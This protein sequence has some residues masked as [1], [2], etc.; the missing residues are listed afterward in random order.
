M[1]LLNKYPVKYAF[2]E[3]LLSY[4]IVTRISPFQNV[5]VDLW[6]FNKNHY[7]YWLYSF[8]KILFIVHFARL[9]SSYDFREEF[10]IPKFKF[11]F[12][13]QAFAIFVKLLVCIFFVLI[14]LCLCFLFFTSESVI[15]WMEMGSSGFIWEIKST[16]SLLLMVVT[17]LFTGGVEELFFRSFFITKLKQMGISLFISSLI[18]SVVF[19]YGHSYYGFIG[20][21]MSLIFGIIFAG[22]YLR[23]KN[24]YYSIFV[25]SFYNVF[26]SFLLFLS[27]Y[28]KELL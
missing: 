13:W 9:T 8:F 15:P 22:M 27:N 6:N 3:I 20:F 18:S 28:S 2:L 17:S 4:F 24:V 16:Q 10:C 11:V 12:V 7:S 21:F 5:N 14:I 19:A 26:V 23:Y 25:H 1:T